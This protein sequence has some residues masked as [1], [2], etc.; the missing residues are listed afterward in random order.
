MIEQDRNAKTAGI[1]FKK[2]KSAVEEHIFVLSVNSKPFDLLFIL[3]SLSY[4]PQINLLYFEN[5][6]SLEIKAQRKRIY[7]PYPNNFFFL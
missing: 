3:S 5:H 4:L 7:L 1:I 6:P 2:L